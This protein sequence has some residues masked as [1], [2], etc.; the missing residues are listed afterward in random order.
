[1]CL[2]VDTCC[3]Y[4]VLDPTNEAHRDFAPVLKWITQGA[5]RFIY[6]GSSY[7]AELR[8]SVRI[9][10]LLK[11]LERAGR[12]VH[13]CDKD[14]DDRED[15]VR[16]LPCP[17]GFNDHHL[18]AMVIVS[19]CRIVCTVDEQAKEQ[20]KTRELYPSGCKKPKIYCRESH[21]TLL[22]EQY[23]VAACRG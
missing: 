20:L 4:S 23:V 15:A 7:K 6:G 12:I 5:G 10:G 9:L 11:E 13:L 3:I 8:R 14:V 16:A 2:V 22:R 1:M 19:R 17:S 18:V 21:K